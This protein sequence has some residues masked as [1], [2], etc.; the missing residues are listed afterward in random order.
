MPMGEFAEQQRAV[1]RETDVGSFF[2]H[3][4][5]LQRTPTA[6]QNGLSRAPAGRS[7]ELGCQATIH[8]HIQREA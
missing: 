3:N 4:V 1:C 7:A 8:H 2:G 6:Q 5:S